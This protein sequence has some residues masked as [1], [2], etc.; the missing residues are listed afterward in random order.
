MSLLFPRTGQ[1]VRF[2][3][4]VNEVWGGVNS[5]G[6]PLILTTILIQHQK[7]KTLDTPP[8]LAPKWNKNLSKFRLVVFLFLFDRWGTCHLTNTTKESRWNWDGPAN[9]RLY[10]GVGGQKPES[11]WISAR[12]PAGGRNVIHGETHRTALA[13]TGCSLIFYEPGTTKTKT[14]K[15][16]GVQ[17]YHPI[18][19]RD[20]MQVM[21]T[22][23][24]D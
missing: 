21:P 24:L 8:D 16:G 5:P 12:L 2:C 13:R 4:G 10:I 7:I 11:H 23:I 6:I 22:C 15:C 20:L 3:W 19:R 18:I 1:V 14:V 9:T 17:G